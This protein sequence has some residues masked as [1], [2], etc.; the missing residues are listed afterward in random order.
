MAMQAITMPKSI[1]SQIDKET[2]LVDLNYYI[3]PGQQVT[4][5]RINFAGNGENCR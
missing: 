4:V 1:L 3:N 5:R 2:K